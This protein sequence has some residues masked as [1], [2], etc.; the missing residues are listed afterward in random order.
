[1]DFI[2]G[3]TMTLPMH[4]RD[5]DLFLSHTHGD[6]DFVLS[7]DRW[8]TE[9]AGFSVWFDAREL[10]GGALLATDLQ[11][12]IERC[13]GVL[14][15]ASEQSLERG[16]VRAEYNAAMDERANH[17]HFRV[18]ALRLGKAGCVWRQ[19]PPNVPAR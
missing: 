7:L 3:L 5:F 13:R 4:K 11:N 9:K 6:L 16:W 1:M 8:L 19:M 18:V 12:A 15:V 10:S 17:E 2:G 14:L